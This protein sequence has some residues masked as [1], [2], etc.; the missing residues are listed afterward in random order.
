VRR[1]SFRRWV[2]G[3]RIWINL[4]L[5]GTTD[6]APQYVAWKN[7]AILGSTVVIINSCQSLTLRHFTHLV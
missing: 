2:V 1:T 6:F 5:R 3:Y 4:V 7:T